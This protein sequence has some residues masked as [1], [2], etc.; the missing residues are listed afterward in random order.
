MKDYL[1]I[2]LGTPSSKAK[3]DALDEKE[4]KRREQAGMQAWGEW[5]KKNEK[6]IVDNGAP[7]GKTK[8]ASPQGIADTRNEM[9]A[10]TIVRADSHEAAARLF[11]N[12]PH[13]TIFRATRSRSWSACRFPMPDRRARPR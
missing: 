8:R 4:R 10:Y 7:L 5:V 13:F 2:Y 3:W 1:A 11:E 12:H 6:S 9:T